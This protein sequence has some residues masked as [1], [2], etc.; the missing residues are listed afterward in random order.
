MTFPLVSRIPR[1]Y[2]FL[3]TT[4]YGVKHEG[5]D[6][7][8]SVGTAVYAPES[9]YWQKI[10]GS[11]IGKG[12]RLTVGN[13]YYKFAHFS[14]WV[15][16]SRNVSEGELIAYTGNT[17]LSTAAHLHLAVYI[18]GIKVDPEVHFNQNNEEEFMFE[19]RKFIP[20]G[21]VFAILKDKNGLGYK[22]HIKTEVELNQ[23]LNE[24]SQAGVSLQVTPIDTPEIFKYKELL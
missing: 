13:K 23:Y 6:Y 5:Q 4:F 10:T 20:D 12:G 2:F 17:G 15:G 14:S 21:R 3:Q 11:Q 24:A 7:A 1:S 19:L 16:V 22:Y 8:A 9:G 18:N